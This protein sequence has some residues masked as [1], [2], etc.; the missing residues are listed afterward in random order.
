MEHIGVVLP[1]W[2]GVADQRLIIQDFGCHGFFFML[3]LLTLLLLFITISGLVRVLL[4]GRLCACA[5][6]ALSAAPPGTWDLIRIQAHGCISCVPTCHSIAGLTV[7]CLPGEG[8]QQLLPWPVS[9]LLQQ[10]FKQ[11]PGTG[12]QVQV[13]CQQPP[14]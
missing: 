6:P 10:H 1:V 2:A 12:L 9:M 4:N 14:I 5:V 3:A 13:T 7:H 11:R 8:G